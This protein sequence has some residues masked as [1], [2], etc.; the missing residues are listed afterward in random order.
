MD[1]F[2]QLLDALAET[3]H[4]LTVAVRCGDRKLAQ[5]TWR[6]VRAVHG[7]LLISGSQWRRLPE[8]GLSS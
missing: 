6:D 3:T 7:E 4:V 2:A 5:R 8:K 1:P